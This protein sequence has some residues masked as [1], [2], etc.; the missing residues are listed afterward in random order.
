MTADVRAS[1]SPVRVGAV[2]GALLVPSFVA[3]GA[4]SV[5]LP[6]IAR[7]LGV[8]FGASS[9]VLASWALS[10]AV[11]MPLFG[12]ISTRV[13]LR[14]CLVT[15]VMLI[16]AG[17][18]LAALAPSLVV[19]IIGRAVG[20]AGAGALVISSYASVTVRLQGADRGRALGIVAA[21][22]TTASACGTLFGGLLTAWPGWRVVVALPALAVLVLIPAARLAPVERRA[23]AR[24][25]PFGAILLTLVGGA[26]V[27]LLQAPSTGLPITVV[28]ALVVIAAVAAVALVAHVRHHPDGFVPKTIVVAP[29]FVAA[30]V[31]GLT[32]FAAYYG[33]LF[34]APALIESATGWGTPLIGAALLPC[35]VFSILGVRLVRTL[36][37]RRSL[38][39]VALWLGAV[40]TIGVLIAALLS[41]QPVFS[42]LGLAL[43]TASFAAGQTV[44]FGLIPAMVKPD[45]QPTA[46]G[47]LDFLIYG[48]SSVG[49]AVVGGLSAGLPLADA[50]AVA[51]ILP[52]AAITVALL[53]RRSAP[54]THGLT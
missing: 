26:V 38:T 10:T 23:G 28:L 33:T 47:L 6:S 25:D 14:A 53:A 51:A 4:P 30:G 8:P 27:V 44:L 54:V 21:V 42:V 48:G 45:E 43:T 22:G 12:R 31:I 13:G 36:S 2:F 7:A 9:W 19:L 34:A 29:Y 24:I 37:Q 17:S 3:L 11:A 35:A 5:A 49:P 46:Q 50:L 40:S 15:G 20:G 52:L 18:I 41:A 32:V 39:V 1:V 16:S